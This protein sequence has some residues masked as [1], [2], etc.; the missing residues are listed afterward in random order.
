MDKNKT[1]EFTF[2]KQISFYGTTTPVFAPCRI[3][4]K[5]KNKIEMYFTFCQ[6]RAYFTD[7]IRTMVLKK[8]VVDDAHG[9][10]I[11]KHDPVKLGQVLL[12]VTYKTTKENMLN[13]IKILNFYSDIG[14]FPK[15][16]L[17]GTI[18]QKKENY[19]W[20]IKI[21]MIY[22]EKPFLM[23]MTTLLIRVLATISNE[24]LE[25]LKNIDDVERYFYKCKSKGS[26]NFSLG[27]RHDLYDRQLYLKMRKVMENH[28]ELFHGLG[29]KTLFPASIGYA[30]HSQGGISSLCRG[31]TFNTILN[32]RAKDL[33]KVKK[34]N[35]E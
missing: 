2:L 29:N 1:K 10:Y 19:S 4:S 18:I 34:V 32:K 12:G 20:A 15:F 7:A 16:K 17:L 25:N 14:N 33:L 24:H 5:D 9:Y 27:D 26:N 22:K 8:R 3:S 11:E 35:K 31:V 21:P 28:K 6:C 23:S 30:F 13:I